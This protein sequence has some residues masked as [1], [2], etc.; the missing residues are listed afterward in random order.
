MLLQ[1][2]VMWDM[3]E[4]SACTNSAGS[5][6]KELNGPGKW[7]NVRRNKAISQFSAVCTLQSIA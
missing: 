4:G 3:K 7:S 1:L 6:R 5:K 2:D